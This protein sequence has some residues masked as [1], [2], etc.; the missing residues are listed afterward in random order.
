MRFISSGPA[1]T[2]ALGQSLAALLRPGDVITL[3]APLGGGKTTL[4]RGLAAGLGVGEDEV[5]SPT[6]VIWQIYPGRLRLHHVDAYRLTSPEEL[7][8]IG[9]AE[10]LAG[11]DVVV[12]E[13][14]GVARTLLPADRLEV[15]LDYAKEEQQRAIELCPQGN[16]QGRLEGWTFEP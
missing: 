4:V 11:G 13:W 16:W 7:E 9:L 12:M 10:C 8:D 14:P 2:E 6:F 15:H 5:S 1:R 3:E